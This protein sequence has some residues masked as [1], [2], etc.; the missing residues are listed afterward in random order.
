MNK[1]ELVTAMAKDSGLTRKESEIA[2]NSF[3]KIVGDALAEGEKVQLVGFGCFTNTQ[4]AEKAGRNPM[5]QE[6]L[7]IPPVKIAKFKTG[8]DLKDKLNK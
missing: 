1:A 3:M 8:K 5:T 4:R 2:L 6:P 7:T